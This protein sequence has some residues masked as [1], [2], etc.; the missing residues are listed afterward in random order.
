MLVRRAPGGTCMPKSTKS[1]FISSN[2]LLQLYYDANPLPQ[3]IFTFFDE[4]NVFETFV[5]KSVPGMKLAEKLELIISNHTC[6]MACRLCKPWTSV[7]LTFF[8]LLL[9]KGFQSYFDRYVLN[10]LSRIF[11]ISHL[12]T[13]CQNALDI[14]L[15]S[16]PTCF[17]QQLQC[18]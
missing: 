2:V 18:A 1:L 6:F 11:Q 17:Y 5:L 7:C 13:E 12:H 3:C 9:Q 4:E 15:I 14:F 16:I 8:T 10:S